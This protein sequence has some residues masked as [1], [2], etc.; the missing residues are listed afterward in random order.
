MSYKF[1][2]PCCNKQLRIENQLSGRKL[3][4]P[5]CESKFYIPQNPKQK[6]IYR[7][8]FILMGIFLVTLIFL[9]PSKA[10]R[11]F[12]Q[13]ANQLHVIA[14]K[15]RSLLLEST[16]LKMEESSAV[17]HALDLFLNA[18]KL[19]EQ[20][21]YQQS[22]SVFELAIDKI[23]KAQHLY[24]IVKG[25]IQPQITQLK[26]T[27]KSLHEPE[28]FKDL[29]NEI[30][31]SKNALKPKQAQK[32]IISLRN[33][34]KNEPEKQTTKV[35]IKV[36]K[37]KLQIPKKISVTQKPEPIKK[38]IES[39]LEVSEPAAINEVIK[40]SEP[41][42][43]QL[44]LSENESYYGE[45]LNGTPHGKGRFS[46]S[47]G[48]YYDGE[49]DEGK[50]HGKGTYYYA[51]GDSFTGEWHMDKRQGVGTYTWKNRT[52]LKAMWQH[53]K[54]N[55]KA[56]FYNS[57]DSRTTL[58]FA[59]GK[60]KSKNKVYTYGSDDV[61]NS[62]YKL[63]GKQQRIHDFT[64]KIHFA[65]N[66]LNL[67]DAKLILPDLP[68][69]EYTFARYFHGFMSERDMLKIEAQIKQ[70]FFKIKR[71]VLRAN[72]ALMD[73][74]EDESYYGELD[75]YSIPTAKL[76][77]V[78]D[79]SG[80]MLKYIKPL[81]ERINKQF[82]NA[83]FIEV[84]SCRLTTFTEGK[85]SDKAADDSTMNAIKYLIDNKGVDSIYWFSDLNGARA[86]E[87]IEQLSKWLDESLVALYIRS[88]GQKPDKRLTEIIRNSGGKFLKK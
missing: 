45:V 76:G 65:L 8:S 71:Y 6:T 61:K 44:E 26:K 11:Q 58:H 18:E 4:C 29:L 46:Y 62:K 77:V 78:L 53:N 10:N 81:K 9:F 22:I 56:F 64:Q 21:K 27:I 48:N 42:V 28:K 33:Q 16:T 75:G 43:K 74:D 52:S 47:N 40:H 25:D 24:S 83:A 7:Y 17:I 19:I 3:Q 20:E 13:K 51:N 37:K 67:N 15:S 85:I 59:E 86:S 50:F 87:A 88:V 30:E 39:E 80:S 12:Q 68:L 84:S 57:D 14:A 79:T 34:L 2:T 82:P 63:S 72:N 31:N 69:H 73:N 1:T 41:E 54:P 23:T 70:D 60:L 32:L 5:H 38:P 66:K 49:W 35:P 36:F 55:G